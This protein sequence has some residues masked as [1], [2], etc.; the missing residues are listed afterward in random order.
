MS[1]LKTLWF[2]GAMTAYASM[3][4]AQAVDDSEVVAL[5]K[6]YVEAH[7]AG[8][9]AEIARMYSTKPGVTSVGDGE[10]VRGWDRIREH[11]S[12]LDNLIAQ[13]GTLSVS[14]G[15]VD[16]MPLGDSSALATTTYTSSVRLGGATREDR[17]AMTLV[18][19]KSDNAWRIIHDHTSTVRENTPL[20]QAARPT[21]PPTPSPPSSLNE[22]PIS[23]GR[24]SEV[25]AA[26]YVH[27]TF[28]LP[29]GSCNI[30]GRMEGIS[31][32]KRDFSALILD[33]DNFRNWSAK[34]ESRAYWQSG[35][36]TVININTTVP[37]PGTFHLVIDNSFSIATPKTVQVWANAACR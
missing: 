18:V 2:A 13:G 34:L 10:I 26:T 24:A 35:R 33:D 7:N 17:G 1:M 30:T 6:M 22:I 16:V 14:I 4:F 3:A 19:Q 8:D 29:A 9:A 21:V 20:A 31:G 5:V 28:E 36:I 32:G 25:P 27:Y 23:N 15:S 11:A 37:G 12:Q